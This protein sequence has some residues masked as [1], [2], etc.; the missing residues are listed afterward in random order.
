MKARKTIIPQPISSTWIP[1]MTILV[2][3]SRSVLI[4]G[5]KGDSQCRDA[6]IT[7]QQMQWLR[8]P[9]NFVLSFPCLSMIQASYAYVMPKTQ[10]DVSVNFMGKKQIF[11]ERSN[12]FSSKRAAIS[13]M[14]CQWLIIFSPSNEGAAYPPLKNAYSCRTKWC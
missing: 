11:Q 7:I 9:S 2:E 3:S 12:V 13:W 14:L 5:G 1:G 10:A 8:K 4:K 6:L